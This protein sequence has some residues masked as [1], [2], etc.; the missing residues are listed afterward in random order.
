MLAKNLVF[1]ELWA[2]HKVTGLR[3]TIWMAG[4]RLW[5]IPP[6]NVGERG[7]PARGMSGL[8]RGRSADPKT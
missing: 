3:S 1:K 5:L 6:A 4:G 8:P 2:G 7:A